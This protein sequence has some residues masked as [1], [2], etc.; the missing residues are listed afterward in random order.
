MVLLG[1][2]AEV[3]LLRCSFPHHEEDAVGKPCYIKGKDRPFFDAGGRSRAG[4][5]FAGAVAGV[6]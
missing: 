5:I 4:R 3:E 2:G 1:I 6:R